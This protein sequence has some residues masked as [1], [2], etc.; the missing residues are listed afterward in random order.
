M[1]RE[2]ERERFNSCLVINL[3]DIFETYFN[4][5]LPVYFEAEKKVS[6]QLQNRCTGLAQTLPKQWPLLA[7]ESEHE[8]Q[9]SLNFF[10]SGRLIGGTPIISGLRN[11]V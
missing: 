9:Y 11:K 5:L 4:P 2:R 10:F 7:G 6:G 8:Y 3:M 1:Q